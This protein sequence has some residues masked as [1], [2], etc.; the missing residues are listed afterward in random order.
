[1]VTSRGKR[2]SSCSC[3]IARNR[4]TENQTAFASYLAELKKQGITTGERFRELRDQWL[5]QHKKPES[6]ET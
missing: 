4:N 1:M 5:K 6:E 3:G 2:Q